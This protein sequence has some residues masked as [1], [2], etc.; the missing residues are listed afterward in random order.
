MACS[1]TP[2][3]TVVLALAKST[4]GATAGGV[5]S[6]AGVIFL[7]FDFKLV[8]VRTISWSYHAETPKEQ[9]TF[10]YGA[11]QVRYSQQ[12]PTGSLGAPILGGW[13]RIKN[14]QDMSSGPLPTG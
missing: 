4:G 14:V 13:N 5:K 7:R 6:A 2:F 8:A 9:V 12:D 1:G 3:E 10:E 11:L